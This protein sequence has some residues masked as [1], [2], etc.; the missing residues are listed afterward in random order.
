MGMIKSFSVLPLILLLSLALRMGGITHGLP[1]V[2]E[3]DEINTVMI[4]LQYGTGKLA[5]PQFLHGSLTSYLLFAAFVGQYLLYHLFG[6]WKSS[7]DVVR[8]FIENPTCFYVL[9]RALIAGLG[10]LIVWASYQA[11]SRLY[12]RMT[13]LLASAIVGASVLQVNMSHL[14]KEDIVASAVLSVTFLAVTSILMRSERGISSSLK[15][16][17]MTGLGIGLAISAK[18]YSAVALVWVLLLIAAERNLFKA[19]IRLTGA[20]A[21]VVVGFG[22]GSPYAIIRWGTLMRNMTELRSAYGMTIPNVGSTSSLF[23]YFCRYLPYAVGL[24]VVIAAVAGLFIGLRGTWRWRTFLV[25]SF[26]IAF[27]GLLLKIGAAFP[28]FLV[29]VV[30]FLAILAALSVQAFKGSAKPLAYALG[31]VLVV[32]TLLLSVRYDRYAMAPDT[33]AMAKAWIETHVPANERIAVEGAVQEL[34]TFGPPLEA[35]Q[36]TLAAELATIKQRGGNG[37]LWQARLERAEASQHP[38]FSLCKAME[39]TSAAVERCKAP[40]CVVVTDTSDRGWFVLSQQRREFLN[41]LERRYELVKQFDPSPGIRYF[42]SQW[43]LRDE[44][45]RLRLVKI[46]SNPVPLVTGPRI[47]I[48]RQREPSAAADPVA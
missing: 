16:Y 17:F 35:N 25:A 23:L 15:G 14:I 40:V 44:F 46:F 45:P 7:N 39:F 12:N 37:R 29:P 18:Y 5:P 20:I 4:A 3:F 30:P 1:A 24:P 33:R 2:Y 34:I 28:H 19:A 31:V 11:G 42:P 21:G 22:I 36:E 9:G 13:G 41:G 47:R 26:P 32:P 48:F 8:Q 6:V 10:T 43:T 38:R 27:M